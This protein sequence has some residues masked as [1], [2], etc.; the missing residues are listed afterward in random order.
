MKGEMMAE[1]QSLTL[2]ALLVG[3]LTSGS[4]ALGASAGT[5]PRAHVGATVT[6]PQIPSETVLWVFSGGTDGLRPL[7]DLVAD[8]TGALYGTTIDGGLYLGSPNTG[9]TVFRLTPSGSGYTKSILWNFGAGTD[10]AGPTGRLLLDNNTGAIYGT[11]Y[12]GGTYN[13][14]TV[15][16]LTPTGSVYT[17]SILWNFGAGNDGK[18]PRAGLIV[19]GSGAFYGTTHWGGAYYK[20]GT[21]S[22][23]GTVFKLTPLGSVYMESVLWNFGNGND[24]SYPFGGSLITDATG[25][26]YGTTQYGGAFKVPPFGGGIAF[27]LTP[28][29]STYTESVLWNF[30]G[31]PDGLNPAGGLLAGK[32]GVLYGMTQQG[33]L[34]QTRRP[35]R[36]GG[37]TVF[38]LTPSGSGYKEHVTWNF[39]RGFDGGFPAG[40]LIADATST[41][42]GT[43]TMGGTKGTGTVFSL[44]T[45]GTGRRESVLWNF[46]C[47]ADGINP[48][49]GLLADANGAL[50]GTTVYGGSSNNY[51][52]VF[53]VTP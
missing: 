24:G 49:T 15:F 28:S 27:K 42:Y 26:L 44:R 53:R 21:C 32:N 5:F 30:S 23:G 48:D 34:N 18:L 12:I 43:T 8:A 6:R 45:S 37:G 51:G 3:G 33:G 11:T 35:C 50:Y 36:C 20:G 47:C 22:C 4:A 10:G 16:K 13:G 2:I 31:T 7:G 25:A 40:G 41:L 38:K 1:I 39:G 19:D 17:E 9:G 14:G 29:G 52:S 46:T